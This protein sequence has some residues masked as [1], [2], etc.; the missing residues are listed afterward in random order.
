MS[1]YLPVLPSNCQICSVI[2]V[3]QLAGA[4]GS[5][6]M[7]CATTAGQV[8][9]TGSGVELHYQNQTTVRTAESIILCHFSQMGCT[10]HMYCN[11]NQ[12]LE[13]NL[14]CVSFITH[15]VTSICENVTENQG[16]FSSKN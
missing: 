9:I 8:N 7:C 6:A 5:E 13:I 3:N 15:E 14:D 2:Y 10:I 11:H 4:Y 1:R 12:A 16:L